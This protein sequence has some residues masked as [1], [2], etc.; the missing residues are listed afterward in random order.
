MRVLP[1]CSGA[2]VLRYRSRPGEKVAPVTSGAAALLNLEVDAHGKLTGSTVAYEHPE[3][4]GFGTAALKSVRTLDF[5]PGFRD[6]KPVAC[7]CTFPVLFIMG[8]KTKI[9]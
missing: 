4:E 8:R 7:R 9:E 2:R 6:G 1:N 5:I 3:R